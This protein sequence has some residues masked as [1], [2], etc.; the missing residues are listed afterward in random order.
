MMSGVELSPTAW[1]TAMTG[2]LYGEQGFYRQAPGPG[3][4]FRTSAHV[5]PAFATAVAELLGRV[6]HALGHPPRLD[7]VDVGSGRGEL[8]VEV[9][10]LAASGLPLAPRLRLHGVELAGRP[11]GLPAAIGWSTEI[12]PVTGVLLANEWLDVV[13]VDVVELTAAGLRTVLVDAEGAESFGPPPSPAQAQWL[14]RWWPLTRIGDRAEVGLP[15]DVAWA[16]A[17]DRV[18][19]GLAVAV[20]YGHLLDTRPADG[21]L[22]GYRSGVVVA[23][24]PDGAS[25][26]T[27]HVA[28]D[29]CAAAAGIPGRLYRQREVLAELGVLATAPD[30]DAARSDPGSYLRGLRDAGDAAEL[31]DP[32]GL[33]GFGWLV[34]GV[35]IAVP[36][37]SER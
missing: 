10:R 15:R 16:G 20:D 30:R 28:W 7:L 3:A 17:V 13:P 29:S 5:G 4:H 24:V 1:S 32:A 14:D 27:A 11:P 34:H 9:A 33:G 12:P 22:V 37:G 19:A 36:L 31:T 25:D 35:G 21:S 26:L 6:D 18:R 23:P 8:L 2:A